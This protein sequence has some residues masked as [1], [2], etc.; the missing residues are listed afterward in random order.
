MQNQ[1]AWYITERWHELAGETRAALLRLLGIALLYCVELINFYG[2]RIGPWEMP[3]VV[4]RD[5][6]LAVTAL[7]FA[8][9]LVSFVVILLIKREFF[10]RALLYFSTA[11]D[12]TFLALMLMIADGPRSPLLPLYFLLLGMTALRFNLPL[13]RFGTLAALASY[14]VVLGYAR[15]YAPEKGVPRYFQLI[16]LVSIALMG[17]LIGQITR[18]VK[19]MAQDYESRVQHLLAEKD[20]S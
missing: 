19:Q 6:H 2:L 17:I 8:W 7:T 10:P 3:S 20:L 12:F 1:E 15:W 4:D 16:F 14:L 11:S 18:R 5:F 13:I 9:S